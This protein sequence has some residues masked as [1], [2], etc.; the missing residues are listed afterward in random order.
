MSRAFRVTKKQVG[1]T[2][3]RL[4][5]KYCS[6]RTIVF[7]AVLICVSVTGSAHAMHTDNSDERARRGEP[8]ERDSESQIKT[9]G[10]DAQ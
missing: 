10:N 8:G 9:S 5:T 3:S 1:V 6:K 2:L 4:P 7:R